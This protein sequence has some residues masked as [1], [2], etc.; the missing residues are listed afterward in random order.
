[1]TIVRDR[2]TI[3][4]EG[5]VGLAD[6]VPVAVVV[7]ADGQVVVFN[8]ASEVL[9]GFDREVAVGAPFVDLLFDADDHERMRTALAGSTASSSERNW[10]IRR[11]DGALLVSSFRL[12]PLDGGLVA[13]IATD[14]VDQGLAE[15]ERAVLLSAEHAARSEAEAAQRRLGVIASASGALATTLEV[16]ELLGR[17]T[18]VL[19]PAI[20][21]WCIVQLVDGSG[22][23]VDVGV[24]SDS[25]AS[26][27]AAAELLGGHPVDLES[28]SPVAKVLRT[29]R[30]LLFAEPESARRAVEAAVP[31][32]EVADLYRTFEPRS[33]LLVP[34]E[35]RGSIRGVLSMAS[36]ERGLTDDDLDVAVEV[37]HRLALA[38]DNIE[39]FQFERGVA[40]TLQR[41][42]L[43]T[44]EPIEGLDVAVRY[45]AATDGAQVGGDW[46]DVI[47]WSPDRVD[48]VVGDVAGHDIH[49]AAG[50]SELRNALRAYS[51]MDGAVPHDTLEQLD[52]LMNQRD[53]AG[54]S[55]VLATLDLAR[56]AVGW[57][58]AGH[59]GPVL[60]TDDGAELLAQPHD[61]L[62][63]IAIPGRRRQTA[64]RE[65]PVGA[66]LVLYTDGA[67]ERTDAPL[68]E[69]IE[70]LRRTVEQAGRRP[71]ADADSVCAEVVE[72]MLPPGTRRSDDVAILVVRRTGGGA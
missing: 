64:W 27:A 38:L 48:V 46:Y 14:T 36:V 37:A 35:A 1:V 39:A 25:A 22:K 24:R 56:G 41:A 20:A 16:D 7:V 23:V 53:M 69:C 42:L 17:V 71:G 54:A 13:W 66:L 44:I 55:C 2:M 19:S 33:S 52:R 62:L 29:G 51:S 59:P 10:R 43:P 32:P 5:V 9:Y 45:L 15:Q 67:V 6:A 68:D 65:L 58:N 11:A 61:W 26:A 12:V 8:R 70:L 72:T 34:V 18:R 57:S 47:P 4:W 50:M 40:E 49:A 31:A 21:D 60:L 30:P 63:G 3:G 28:D